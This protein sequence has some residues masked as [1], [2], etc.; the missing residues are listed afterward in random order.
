M[1]DRG[2]MHEDGCMYLSVGKTFHVTIALCPALKYDII[3]IVASSLA[4]NLST[5]MS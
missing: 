4:V 2:V 1:V 5:A 3:K